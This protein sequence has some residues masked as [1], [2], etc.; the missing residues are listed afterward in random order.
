M[1]SMN[2]VEDEVEKE[3]GMNSAVIKSKSKNKSIRKSV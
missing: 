2:I 3:V 1:Q